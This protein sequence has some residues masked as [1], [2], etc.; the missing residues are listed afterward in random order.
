MADDVDANSGW[1]RHLPPGTGPDVDLLAGGS[2]GRVWAAHWSGDPRRPVL[3]RPGEADIGAGEL[4]ERS[5]RVATR[6][7]GAGLRP[8][9]RVLFSAL[10]SAQL[11][12]ALVAAVRLGLVL[13]PANTEYRRPEIADIVR[14]AQPAAA[15]VDAE[16]RAGWVRAAATSPVAITSPA[17]ELDGAADAVLDTGSAA[18]PLLLCYTSG[19][20]GA[21]KGA[22]L[23]HGNVLASLAA[24]RLAW[25]WSPDD[26]LVLALPLFHVHGLVVGL[27]GSL[28]AGASVVLLP[29]FDPHVVVGAVRDHAA[30]LMF[31]VPTMYV[32][33]IEEPR[34]ADLA[35]LRLC[36]SGSAPMPASLHESVEQACGQRVLE[37]YGMSETVMLTSNPHDGERRAGTVGFPLPGVHMRLAENGEILVR[38]SNVSTGYWRNDSATRRAFTPDGWFRTGDVGDVDGDGYLR[39]VGRTKELIITGGY[40]VYP[41]EVEDVLREHPGV[42]DAAVVGTPSS[43]WGETVVAFIVPSGGGVDEAALREHVAHALAPYKRPRAFHIVDELPRNAMGKVLRDELS[44]SLL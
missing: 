39:I 42:G 4:E 40:N 35:R 15:I 17:V 31:G 32:R 26:R 28:A 16:E 10:P 1:L 5:R 24:L 14:D 41:R 36:V 12:T 11:V 18:D 13:V 38:G 23:S 21:P 29:R 6:L 8:G 19:T 3:L 43:R 25:R 7:A 33:L 37:R 27:A 2:L 30:T 34:V 44:R 9:D 20:T 22:L